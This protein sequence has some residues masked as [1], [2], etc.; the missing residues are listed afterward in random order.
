MRIVIDGGGLVTDEVALKMVLAILDRDDGTVRFTKG[1]A[2][3]IR[4]AKT[5]KTFKVV[6]ICDTSEA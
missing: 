2:V 4:S 1:F 6:R 3:D 5:Q